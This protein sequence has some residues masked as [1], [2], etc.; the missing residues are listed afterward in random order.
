M[1]RL[2]FV[3]VVLL[4]ACKPRSAG[5]DLESL[6]ARL[7]DRD[8][9][10]RAQAAQQLRRLEAKQAAPRIA[11]L[12][13]DP[14]VKQDAVLALQ[15]LAGPGELDA[16]LGA[17]ET[18]V[19][20]GSDEAT[21]SANRIN[22]LIAEALG[23]VGDPRAGPELLRLARATD[24][25][26]RLAAVEALGN[27][28]SKEAVP[29]LAHLVD[30]PAAP[31]LL[32]KRSID[33]L[34]RIGDPAAIPALA[35]GLVI[36]RQGVSFVPESSF[37]LFVIGAP[38]VEPL[39]RILQDQDSGFAAWAKE[40]NLA[41]AGTYARVA[42]VLGDLGDP[43]SLLPLIAKL[44]YTDPDPV[45]DTSR[46][47][48]NLVRMFA[49]S[50]LGRMRAAQAAPAVQALVSTASAQ[51]EQLTSL[52]AEALVW[53]G[54]RAQARELMKKAQTGVLKLRLA[55]AQSAALFGEPVLGTDVRSVAQRESKEPRQTCLRQL[56]ELTVPVGDPGR[57][58]DLVATQ[59]GELSKPLE[60]ARA[61]AGDAPCWLPKLED[62]D[63][64]VR[65]RAAYELGRAGAAD[66]VPALAKAIG[67]EQPLV[68]EAATRALDWLVAVPAARTALKG[69]A[70]QLSAQLVQE[71]G[72]PRSIKSYEELRRLQIKL[73]RL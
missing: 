62:R 16:L 13:A 25:E 27:I 8:P 45:P 21:R 26:V 40:N 43:R 4:L 61:C 72:K 65:A 46:L 22:A 33:A 58:C 28:R 35:R 52:A 51:D 59:F 14:L 49:A 36:E 69:V 12:L 6:I 1:R 56:D 15:D 68:R 37:A 66:A 34:G 9:K 41:P 64:M 54:D 18:T 11:A 55:V 44:K 3:L 73:S 48:S 2:G 17:L 29:E 5:G 50:A 63:P 67:E 71:Q 10:V 57:A 39:I 19:G 20:A 23:N 32:I 70:P 30:D 47:L 38:A 60:A 31:P 53:M 7:D 42:R 24:V